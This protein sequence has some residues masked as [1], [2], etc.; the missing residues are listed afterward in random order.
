MATL[1]QRLSEKTDKELLFYINNVDKHT[2]E[3]VQLA[4]M[5][6]RSRSVVLP[7][8]I[9][10][11]ISEEIEKIKREKDLLD[12][13]TKRRILKQTFIFSLLYVGVGTLA[14]L[15]LSPTS[16]FYGSWALVV[17]LIT[18]PVNLFSLGI[19]YA[20]DDMVGMILIIQAIVF[21]IFWLI[22]YRIFIGMTK[23]VF[24]TW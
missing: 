19:A 3:A 16:M 18:L 11:I 4:L 20:D 8:N 17:T 7:E 2:E 23:K 5:E 10:E 12:K 6:L 13:E 15:S 9:A 21:L 22:L 14:V 1:K 24:K